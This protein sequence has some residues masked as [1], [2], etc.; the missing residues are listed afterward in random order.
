MFELFTLKCACYRCKIKLG[1]HCCTYVACLRNIES[2]L[3]IC[4]CSSTRRTTYFTYNYHQS[5]IGL[6]VASHT[7]VSASSLLFSESAHNDY[8]LFFGAYQTVDCSAM[9]DFSK[10]IV[11]YEF[12][13]KNPNARNLWECMVQFEGSDEKCEASIVS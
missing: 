9:L 5:E 4:V 7:L 10:V 6:L 11:Y 13:R 3:T 8:F 1:L 2:M 12:G